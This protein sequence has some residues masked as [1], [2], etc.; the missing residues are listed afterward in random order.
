MEIERRDFVKTAAFIGGIGSIAAITSSVGCSGENSDNI[1][2]DNLT[3]IRSEIQRL[4]DQLWIATSRDEI[5][6]KLNLYPRSLDRQDIEIGMKVF[7]KDSYID[8]GTAP[9]GSWT[10]QGTGP[11]WVEYCINTIDKGIT[12]TG[13]YYAHLIF[14]IT[15]NV[16]GDQAGSEIYGT[17][18]VITQM[19]DKTYTWSMSVARY[20]DK[21]EYRDGEWLIIERVVTNDFGWSLTN[22]SLRNPYGCSFDSDDPSYESLAYGE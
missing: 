22:S 12:A 3:E 2:A 16:N 20:C 4:R 21:W 14:N 7:A 6:Q 9:D 19:E 5:R 13:G 18:P 1:D 11:E 17:A 10:W 8:Y 15:I